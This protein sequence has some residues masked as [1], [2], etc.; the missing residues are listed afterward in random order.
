MH[1]SYLIILFY[2]IYLH[3]SYHLFYLIYLQLCISHVYLFCLI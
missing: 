2:L 1:Q 3:G